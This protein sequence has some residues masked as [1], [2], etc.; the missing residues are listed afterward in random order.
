MKLS[1]AKLVKDRA[2]HRRAGP[3]PTTEIKRAANACCARIGQRSSWVFDPA[4]KLAIEPLDGIVVRSD[5]TGSSENEKVKQLISCFSRLTTTSG[6]KLLRL[7]SKIRGTLCSACSTTR[8]RRSDR[9]PLRLPPKRERGRGAPGR[10]PRTVQRCTAVRASSFPRDP[11]GPGYRRRSTGSTAVEPAADKP[12]RIPPQ[13]ETGLVFLEKL[14][15]EMAPFRP[16][17][18]GTPN[19]NA[20]RARRSASLAIFSPQRDGIQIKKFYRCAGQRTGRRHW[21]NSASR[22]KPHELV[23]SC[24]PRAG[25]DEEAGPSRS[26]IRRCSPPLQQQPKSA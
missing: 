18:S 14:G 16:S 24:S 6:R 5:S 22:M 26:R 10:E 17:S 23:R 11:S 8:R 12:S 9:Q 2:I 20:T 21:V 7:R 19:P 4:A 1:T 15:T 13:H 25:A 3:G